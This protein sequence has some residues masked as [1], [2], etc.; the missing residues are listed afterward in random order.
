MLMYDTYAKN[1]TLNMKES[2]AVHIF[3]RDT[4]ILTSAA[5]LAPLLHVEV[6]PGYS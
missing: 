2:P 1:A 4:I 5:P 3:L 6:L